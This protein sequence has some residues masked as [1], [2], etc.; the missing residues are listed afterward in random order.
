MDSFCAYHIN[1]LGQEEGASTLASKFVLLICIYINLLLILILKH[2]VYSYPY[3]TCDQLADTIL[4]VVNFFKYFFS[5]F[6]FYY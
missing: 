6:N 5:N 1:P 3:P 2:F 4:D